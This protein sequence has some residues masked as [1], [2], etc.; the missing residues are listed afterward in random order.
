MSLLELRN[1]SKNYANH[2]ACNDISLAI[3]EG[4]FFT[5]LGPSGCGK[6][7]LLRLIS[8]L[9]KPD[10][11]QI[12]LAKR[13]ITELAVEKRNI[14]MVFQNYALFP[15]FNVFENVAYG[16]KLKKVSKKTI[17]AKVAEYL[18][19]VKLTGYDNRKISEL[20]GGEQQRVA[21][22]RTLITEPS[23]LLLDE[24]FSNLDAK[25]RDKMRVELKSIQRR[26]NITT[27]FVTHDQSEAFT[28]SDRIAVLNEGQCIQVGSPSKI[29]ADPANSFVAA[30]VGETNLFTVQD[31]PFNYKIAPLSKFVSVR[32][33]HISIQPLP[34]GKAGDHPG[35]IVDFKTNGAL[36]EYQIKLKNQLL[37]VVVLNI[38]E[39]DQRLAI[40]D[41]VNVV[42]NPVNIQAFVS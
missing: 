32:P 19:L 26:I 5:L 11:G 18:D 7:T 38:L 27:V 8:G 20:S 31:F 25:L 35:I 22:A 29:Y 2:P 24:P 13:N 39:N 6:T 37:K 9:V 33:Q 30:F 12:F 15:H 23:L 3:D 40:G 16:L 1:I 17:K 36:L 34:S 10:N 41:S 42:I 14:G 21:L 28:L 4:E